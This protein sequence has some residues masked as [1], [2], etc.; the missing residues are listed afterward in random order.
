MSER[1]KLVYV[2]NPNNPTGGMVTRAALERFLDG[3]PEHVLPVLDEAYFE[4]VDDPEYPD[5]ASEQLARGRRCVVLRTFSKIYGLAGFR[6]G[7][8]LCPPDVA[9]ACLKVKNAFDVTQSALDA[10]LASL[11]AHDEVARRRDETRAGPRAAGR[12]AAGARVRAAR[13]RRQLPLRRRRRRRRVRRAPR[14]AGRDRAARSG[15]S[16][17]PPRCASAWGLRRS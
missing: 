13:G 4:Y 7:Y 9:A 2:T 1:T 10:A 17:I 5:G 16:A 14:A 12:R 8:G 3:L 15:R 6:V 11:G